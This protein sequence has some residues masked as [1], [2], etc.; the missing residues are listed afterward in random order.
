MGGYTYEYLWSYEDNALSPY[1]SDGAETY[2]S[3]PGPPPTTP[4]PPPPSPFPFPDRGP[5][6]KH[7]LSGPVEVP[8]RHADLGI[9]RVDLD[10]DLTHLQT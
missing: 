8:P 6:F 7:E 4:L 5:T 3:I 9:V 10:L 1:R 2:P